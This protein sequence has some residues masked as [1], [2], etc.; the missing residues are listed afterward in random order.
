MYSAD[1]HIYPKQPTK[2]ET[3]GEMGGGSLHFGLSFLW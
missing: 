3:F 1:I 2:K